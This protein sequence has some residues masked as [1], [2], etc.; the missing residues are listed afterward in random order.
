MNSRMRV[1]TSLLSSNSAIYM[2]RTS[3]GATF[4]KPWIIFAGKL[5]MDASKLYVFARD[6]VSISAKSGAFTSQ[7]SWKHF[8]ASHLYFSSGHCFDTKVSLYFT[9]TSFN[10]NMS[11]IQS[12]LLM[13]YADSCRF[14]QRRC[15][16]PAASFRHWRATARRNPGSGTGLR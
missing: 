11:N 3:S 7:L 10:R 14:R 2:A 13:H 5:F 15:P 12:P 16:A 9:R 1:T 4:A 8:T 6:R